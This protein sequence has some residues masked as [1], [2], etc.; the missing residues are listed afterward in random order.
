VNSITEITRY[1]IKLVYLVADFSALHLPVDRTIY[2]S[3][4]GEDVDTW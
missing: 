1:I 4:E 2:S 3:N